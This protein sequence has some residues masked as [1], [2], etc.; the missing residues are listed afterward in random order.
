MDNPWKGFEKY[1]ELEEAVKM[2]KEN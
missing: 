2:I 1:I